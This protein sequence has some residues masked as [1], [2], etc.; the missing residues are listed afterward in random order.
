MSWTQFIM[1]VL[2]FT[3]PAALVVAAV[4]VL[5]QKFFENEEKKRY[6]ELRNNTQK[7][8]LPIRLQA[9]ERLTLLLE[10]LSVNNLILRVKKPGMSAADLMGSLLS[11]IRAEFDHNLSQQIYISHEAWQYVTN[12]KEALIK[13]INISYSS[14]P[15]GASSM[16]LSKAIFENA[17][18]EDYPATYKAL[19]YIKKEAQELF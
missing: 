5:L 6:Y 14:L 10:R 12:G 7:S 8:I 19:L 11:E 13:L 4:Y 2:K 1:D 18:K 9:Y 17:M 16:D 15:Q 3:I